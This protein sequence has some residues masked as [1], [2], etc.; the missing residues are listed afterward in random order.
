[1]SV[2]CVFG[3]QWGDE[4]K[5]RVVD[6]LS[7]DSDVVVRYQGGANAGHTVIVGTEKY[8]LH[9]LPSGV[10]QPG[11]MNV[12]GNGVVV[13]PWTLIQEL[14]ELEQRGISL[15][16][17]LLLS[18]RAHVVLPYHKS[19]DRAMEIL[20]GGDAL[21]TTSRGI[22]P[23]YGDKYMREGFRVTELLRPE[24]YEA[25]LTAQVHA[26]NALLERAGLPPL[27][28][29]EVLQATRAAVERLRPFVADTTA[30]LLRAWRE[31]KRIL[32][33][34]AQAFGL[35]VDHGS[36]PYVTSSHTGTDGVSPGTGLPP[37][38]VDRVVGI[39]KAYTTR[40]GAG[41][42]PTR[43]DG[44]AG[45]HL[46]SRG[47][48][49]GATTGRPRQ[50]GWF[51]AVLARRAAATQGVDAVAV[52]KLDVLSGLE[53]IRV[54]TAYDLDGRRLDVPPA[55]AA[56]WEA[57]RPVYERFEGWTEDLGGARRFADLPRAARLYVRALQEVLGVS[58]EMVSVGAERDQWIGT[59][60]GVPVG[61]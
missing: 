44:P 33:E 55:H 13:D 17:R 1:M 30:W 36:Y 61:V 49:F 50:C 26:R 38:A 23:A 19:I 52:M 32:L 40:V 6:L 24:R 45:R 27:D 29:A 14:D 2:T 59:S 15:A 20:R 31:G 43:D 58:V 57:C 42:F 34:G 46:S 9:L 54:C 28:A 48:E 18:D 22:G 7:A 21:G 60:A 53:E 37:R 16:G 10:I 8:V 5:G 39:V 25:R 12:I 35:D 3:M 56:D 41:P 4:G 51:D 47:R 11:T